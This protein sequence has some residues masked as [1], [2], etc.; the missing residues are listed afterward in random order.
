MLDKCII[1]NRREYEYHYVHTGGSAMII[2]VTNDGKFIMVKQYR[3]LNDFFSIEFPAGGVKDGQNP[4]EIARKELIEESG[5]DGTLKK[6]GIFNPF[7]GVTDEICHVY[8]AENLTKS[9]KENKDESEEFEI[10]YKTASE[11]N[12]MIKNNE[13]ID[14]MSMAAWAMYST[15]FTD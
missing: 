3:Y 11:I 13:T 15:K 12:L 9:D 8:V 14:G 10:L 1:P 6:I 4:D 2:P 7:N 5:F